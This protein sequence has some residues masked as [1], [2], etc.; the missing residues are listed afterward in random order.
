MGFQRIPD[1]LIV[2]NI[3]F[4][5]AE[6][7]TGKLSPIMKPKV[8]HIDVARKPLQPVT[9]VLPL[10]KPLPLPSETT[11]PVDEHNSSQS[12]LSSYNI[13]NLRLCQNEAP[14]LLNHITWDFSK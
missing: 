6:T 11:E 5:I 3:Y 4:V 12:S 13:E 8:R 2:N 9:Q 1:Q 7:R 14:T 10:E